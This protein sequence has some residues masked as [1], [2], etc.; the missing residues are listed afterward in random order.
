KPENDHRLATSFSLSRSLRAAAQHIGHREPRNSRQT[1]LK[2]PPPG[3][4]ANQIAICRLEQ[5]APPGLLVLACVCGRDW[6]SR[7]G[8]VLDTHLQHAA[9]HASALVYTRPQDTVKVVFCRR[10]NLAALQTSSDIG[11]GRNRWCVGYGRGDAC[12]INS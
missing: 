12:C 2:K 1:R 11:V 4:D 7:H 10:V 3:P 9:E 6:I 5:S 8:S